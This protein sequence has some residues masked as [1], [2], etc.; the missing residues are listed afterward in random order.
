MGGGEGVGCMRMRSLGPRKVLRFTLSPSTLRPLSFF[1][2]CRL[3]LFISP[4]AVRRSPHRLVG[5]FGGRE[6]G[7]DLSS[8]INDVREAHGEN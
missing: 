5:L 2:S 8:P 3:V 7:Y 1:F 6:T 4:F